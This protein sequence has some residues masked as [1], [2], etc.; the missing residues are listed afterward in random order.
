MLGLKAIQGIATGITIQTFNQIYPSWH[1]WKVIKAYKTLDDIFSVVNKLSAKAA[2]VPIYGYDQNMEDLPETDK[3]TVFLRTLTFTQRI[4]MFT[5]LY[6]RGEVVIYKQKT[7]G[8]NGTV[9]KIAFINPSFITLVLTDTWPEEVQQYWFRDPNRGIDTLLERDEVMFIKN[10]NPSDDYR[11]G[12]RGYSSV[13]ALTKRLVRMESNM[14]NSVA[15][16]QNGG[17]PG[18][19]YAKDIPNT[20]VGKTAIDQMKE[21]FGRFSTNS[22]NKGAPFIQ[23]GEMGYFQIGSSLVDMDSIELEKI[24]FKKICNAFSTFDILFGSDSASTESNVKEVRQM[25]WTDAIIPKIQLVEDA[26]NQ[27]LVTDFG[28]GFKQVKFDLGSVKDLQQNQLDLIKSLAAAP[29]MIPNDVLEAMGYD[30]V[31]DPTM[32]L[33]LVK[34]GYQP[35]DQF[36]PLPPIE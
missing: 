23:A 33:P 36:E 26:F 24:D 30:R 20:A 29:V 4:E 2:S 22:A 15:Q 3:L 14:N 25:N 9:E 32:D 18:V 35:L 34:T 31:D 19:M 27:E 11:E 17:V 12:W 6:L 28:V 16:M 5:W 7:L 10:F 8:V 1:S 13:D 21:N